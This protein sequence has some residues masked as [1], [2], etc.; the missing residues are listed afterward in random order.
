MRKQD[1][2]KET[3]FLLGT[4]LVKYHACEHCHAVYVDPH[5][6]CVGLACKKCGKANTAGSRGYFGIAV[7]SLIN[8]MQE[9]FHK[10][11]KAAQA[12]PGAKDSNNS[13]LAVVLFFATLRDVLLKHFL[14]EMMIAHGLTVAVLERLFADSQSRQQML[15]SLFPALT[16]GVKWNAAL[17]RLQAQL[18]FD[19]VD[20]NDFLKEVAKARNSFLHEGSQW[21]IKP[22]MAEQCMLR[23]DELLQLYV[24]LHNEFV[25][26]KH[27]RKGAPTKP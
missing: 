14:T 19:A 16:G 18:S 13:P 9:F 10:D 21:P 15:N 20:L 2:L 1:I 5:Q 25:L 22:V 8:L 7:W 27:K 11:A 3:Q 26:E 17:A 23:I 24:A 12:G 6:T 4:L